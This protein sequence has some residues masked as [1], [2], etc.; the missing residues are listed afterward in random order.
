MHGKMLLFQELLVF[1][2]KKSCRYTL[3]TSCVLCHAVLSSLNQSCLKLGSFVLYI[4]NIVA[5]LD[6]M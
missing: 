3:V 5:V 2:N 6:K 4:A 1:C